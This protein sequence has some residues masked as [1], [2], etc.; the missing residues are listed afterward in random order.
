MK[1]LAIVG[2]GVF[3]V[4]SAL[5]CQAETMALQRE[6]MV[7]RQIEQRGVANEKVLNAMREVRR[8]LF[9]PEQF[10]Q[11]AY[12]DR[13]LPIGHDQTISQPYIVAFMTQ[14][15]DPR[16]EDRVLEIGTGSGYQAAILAEIVKQ[17]YT[18][19]ILAPLAGN[20][21]QLLEELGYD[22]VEVKLGDGYQGWPEHAPFDIIVV[23]AAPPEVPQTLIDQL[24]VGGRMIVPV[25]ERYQTLYL[26]EKTETDIQ[27]SPLV[28]VRFVPMVPTERL[29]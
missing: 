16:G 8:D 4:M 25:G 2:I 6:Q 26:I 21:R 3:A 23:T 27:K 18:I 10:R 11:F 7:S 13:P 28:P 9:V 20:A 29:E 15:V 19:E 17:V 1:L 24:A 12:L 5:V 22:N 14:A